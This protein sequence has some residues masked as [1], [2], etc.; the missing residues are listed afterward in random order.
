MPQ[1]DRLASQVVPCRKDF[2]GSDGDG[3]CRP[4]LREFKD[5]LEG[6]ETLDGIHNWREAFATVVNSWRV[7]CA[8]VPSTFR[9]WAASPCTRS[10]IAEK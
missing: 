3:S 2:E 10:K 5:R 6:L 4:R 7:S 9:P 1:L 8:C